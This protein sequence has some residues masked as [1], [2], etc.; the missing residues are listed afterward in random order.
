MKHGIEVLVAS[1]AIVGIAN[2]QVK[3]Y[4]IAGNVTGPGGQPVSNATVSERWECENGHLSP[5]SKA[6]TTDANGRFSGSVSSVRFP[7]ALMAVDIS[8]EMGDAI[9]LGSNPDEEQHLSLKLEPLAN[10]SMNVGVKQLPGFEETV[11]MEIFLTDASAPSTDLRKLPMCFLLTFGNAKAPLR[12]PPGHFRLLVRTRTISYFDH[13]FEV[14]QAS[15][16]DLGHL[17]ADASE[18]G[19]IFGHEL[20]EWHLAA[21]RGLPDSVKLKDF[22][23]KYLLVESWAYWCVPCCQEGIPQ[24]MRFWDEHKNQQSRFAMVAL[25]TYNGTEGGHVTS[26]ADVDRLTE[27]SK[28]KYWGGRAIPVPVLLDDSDKT[29]KEWGIGAIPNVMLIDPNGVLVRTDDPYAYLAKKLAESAPTK[30]K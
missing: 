27:R 15:S 25:H 7:V 16:V 23:G 13:R 24:L 20:P 2:A 6:F 22:R 14:P 29:A 4:S 5:D 19:L 28:A 10:V 26:M 11:G 18:E 1:L 21:A 12:L 3:S 17:E 8:G 9:L 30:T